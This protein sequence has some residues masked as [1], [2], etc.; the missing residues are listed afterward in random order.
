MK[1]PFR[2]GGVVQGEQFCPRPDLTKAL[3]GHIDNGQN[4]YV[5]GKRRTG[6]TSLI[7]EAARQA[8]ARMIYVDLMEAKSPE[9]FARRLL[10][11]ILTLERES[12]VG[13]AMK[14]FASLRPSFGVDPITGLPTINFNFAAPVE[15]ESVAAALDLVPG[16]RRKGKPLVVIFDEFQDVLKMGE[17]TSKKLLAAL[18]SKIQFHEDIPYIFSGSDRHDM[19]RI[20][21][22]PESAFFKSAVLVEVGP[23]PR[24]RFTAFLEE[25][26]VQSGRTIN[27][28]LL[29]RIFEICLDIPGD[30]QQL[31]R[32]LWELGEERL[33]TDSL[34]RALEVIWSQELKGYET[35]LQMLSAQ[36][37]KVLST[38]ARIGGNAPTS[39]AF[40]REAGGLMP[41]SAKSALGRLLALRLVFYYRGEYRF[42]NP[43]FRAW[44]MAWEGGEAG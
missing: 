39:A 3:L 17:A 9:D 4:C 16:L 8:G 42:V 43:F 21:I 22:D 32:A 36:Q 33:E 20:F 29:D 34:T 13:K 11:S 7:C 24:K 10:A 35:A 40:L 14:I 2:F 41:S 27:V 26:F 18:R 38:I 12:F 5:Q 1:N 6:K 25:K 15:P 31:C 28:D 30:V 44:L 37:F 23:I 19:D